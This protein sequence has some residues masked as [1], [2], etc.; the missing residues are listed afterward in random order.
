MPGGS[1]PGTTSEIWLCLFRTPAI[2]RQV[3]E[4]HDR[5]L[6][7]NGSGRGTLDLLEAWGLTELILPLCLTQGPRN[8]G[9]MGSSQASGETAY[10]GVSTSLQTPL[11]KV[12]L[13]PCMGNLFGKVK[14]PET[15]WVKALQG[16]FG[17]I[18]P[19]KTLQPCPS[20]KMVE[21]KEKRVKR[22]I[23][24]EILSRRTSRADYR[25]MASLPDALGTRGNPLGPG[26]HS[27]ARWWPKPY[28]K[29]VH[30]C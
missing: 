24:Q 30:V 15:L 4:Y 1:D 19:Q 29:D 12:G 27:Q 21:K 14:S 10:G 6:N 17:Q 11:L 25:E 22:K 3:R 18:F 16:L 8:G 26:S 7:R 13:G 9:D 23:L 2:L 20:K 28:S 5:Q